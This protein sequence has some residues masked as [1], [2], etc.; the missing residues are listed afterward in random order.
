MGSAF[1]RMLLDQE[2]QTVVNLDLLTYAGSLDR[3]QGCMEDPRHHFI[4]GD[5]L[6]G[7]LV[8][9]LIRKHKID[10]VVHFAA[11]THVDRSIEDPKLFTR[12]NVEGTVSLLEVCRRFSE[13]HFHHISTD[14]V[15]GSIEE[16]E[17]SEQSPYR[18]N[19][20]Y[21]ASKAASDHFVRAF[22]TT[23]GLSTTISHS[24]N[25]F[26]PH[27][28]PEKFIPVMVRACLAKETLPVYGSGKNVRDWLF[29]EDHAKAV[30]SI[31]KHG[32]RGETYNISGEKRLG[33]LDLLKKLIGLVASEKGEP[34]EALTQLIKHVDDRPGHDFRYALS[35]Q[36][37]RS[38]GWDV[39]KPFEEQLRE[40]VRWHC[41]D[42]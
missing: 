15:Y 10:T 31:L 39:E 32:L 21:A 19:S 7:G 25:N 9:E 37:T 6:Q 33:N 27:Q 36:K 1:V 30:M 24:S 4:R 34:E 41:N 16:G 40:T 2:A 26:G 8:E 11:E 38:L 5:I 14:E 17:F 13:I 18:P 20:P 23:Y 35:G 22:A 3:L 28:Y 29:V 42:A 12:T